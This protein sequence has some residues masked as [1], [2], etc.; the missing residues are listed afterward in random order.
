ML[1]SEEILLECQ[2]LA[3]EMIIRYFPING[4]ADPNHLPTEYEDST[5]IVIAKQ[6]WFS[7]CRL[8][9]EIFPDNSAPVGCVVDREN[10]L[11]E[12]RSKY[13]AKLQGLRD[14]ALTITFK[15]WINRTNH[16]DVELYLDLLKQYTRE[17]LEIEIRDFMEDISVSE[18]Q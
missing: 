2:K 5:P 12:I 7:L 9:G 13:S 1:S 3:D 8:W 18:N 4:L 10:D 14:K 15:E 16:E 17:L 11:F 6:Y